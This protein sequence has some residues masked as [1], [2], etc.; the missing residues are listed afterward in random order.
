[1]KTLLEKIPKVP[2]MQ[3]ANVCVFFFL[4]LGK[5]TSSEGIAGVK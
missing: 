3:R 5:K 2:S 4:N 1:M